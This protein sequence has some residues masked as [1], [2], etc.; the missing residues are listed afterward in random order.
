MKQVRR[1]VFETN[2]SSTHTLTIVSKEKYDQWNRGELVFSAY[3]KPK[4]VKPEENMPNHWNEDEM[5]YKSFDEYWEE[6]EYET[7]EIEHTTESGDEI[8]AFG[9]YGY[10]G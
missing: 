4:F 9:Y 8:V 1:G 2:S 7:F 6:L 5:E 3:A 10:N